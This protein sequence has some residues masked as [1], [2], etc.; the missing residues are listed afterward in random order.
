MADHDNIS[1]ILSRGVEEVIDRPDLESQLRSKK[2]LRVKLGIDPTSK[3]I[4]IGRAIALWKLYDLQELGHKIVF[5]VGDFTAL[6]GDTSDKDSERPMLTKEQVKQNLKGYIKQV[7]KIIDTDKAE[8]HFNSKWLGKLKFLEIAE[9]AD[10]FSLREFEAR[11]NIAK[12]IKEGKRVSL[13]EVL[14]PLM[15]GYDSVA[16]KADLEVGGTDQRFNLLAGRTLQ[17]HYRQKPQNIMTFSLIEGADGRKMSSSWGNVINISDAPREMYGKT[18]SI[19]DGLI[20][21]YMT[22]CT[23]MSM[24]LIFEIKRDL[25]SQK[26]NPRDAK[27][28]LA[29]ELVQMYH[30][31]KAAQSAQAYFEKVHKDKSAPE[32]LKKVYVHGGAMLLD[33]LVDNKLVA[34]KSEGRRVIE[35]DGVRI[36]GKS[37]SDPFYKFNAPGIVNVGKRRFLR[38]EIN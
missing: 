13:R 4:H 5:I 33:I 27:A 17:K 23:R 29:R 21:K 35:Q 32:D 6:I 37:C 34:S 24:E 14:Y 18:M 11:E 9:Q 10:E 30:G 26:M 25:E 19:L 1:E 20:I 36:D 2:K 15:Q 22:S 8:I 16:I 38:I 7:A 28:M 3:Y 31:A 12:R